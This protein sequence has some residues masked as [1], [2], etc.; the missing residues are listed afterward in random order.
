MAGG[1][2]STH[3]LGGGLVFTHLTDSWSAW[4]LELHRV[5][6]ADGTAGGDLHRPRGPRRRRSGN[7]G[8]RTR[9]GMN[10][11]CCGRD[12]DSGG[13]LRA[14]TRRWVGSREH[15][16]RAFDVVALQA[17]GFAG[18]QGRGAAAQA[19]TSP[20]LLRISKSGCPMKGAGSWEGP[21][22]QTARQA[23]ARAGPIAVDEGAGGSRRRLAAHQ[24]L[25]VGG[26]EPL[27]RPQLRP[28]RL[29]LGVA[30]R[31][32]RSRPRA[33]KAGPVDW[34]AFCATR[35]LA[36]GSRRGPSGP[37]LNGEGE[38]RAARI[39]LHRDVRPPTSPSL[40]EA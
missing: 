22:P 21:A 16:G 24:Q 40:S 23:R 28:N 38:A 1:G 20:S 14:A 25:L 29:L 36:T 37:S 10:V 26:R 17:Q 3:D 39:E 30:G 7:R 12:W 6:A 19:W 33:R 11:L 8:R 31:V 9:I 15:W 13:P 2:P 18:G 27:S 4:L 35:H 34:E 5:L 32:G